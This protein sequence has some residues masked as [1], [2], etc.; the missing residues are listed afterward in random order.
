MRS[1]GLIRDSERMEGHIE[2]NEI[3]EDL[4]SFIDFT[5]M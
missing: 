2:V 1:V 3:K 5:K 4:N